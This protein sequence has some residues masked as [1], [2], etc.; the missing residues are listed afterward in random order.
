MEEAAI[1]CD[2]DTKFNLPEDQHKNNS[3]NDEDDHEDGAAT[4][5]PAGADFLV[6]YGT[7]EGRL[8]DYCVCDKTKKLKQYTRCP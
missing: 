3:I 6:C 7:A 5:T 1:Q 8:N 2:T 4:V